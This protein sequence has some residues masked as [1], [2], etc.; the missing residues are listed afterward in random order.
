MTYSQTIMG[1]V[2]ANVKGYEL[3]NSN[4]WGTVRATLPEFEEIFGQCHDQGD[5]YNVS[6]E[7]F[8]ETPRGRATVRD[9]HLN[10]PDELSITSGNRGAALWL[11]VYLR[12]LKFKAFRGSIL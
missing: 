9:F 10:E 11:I 7:W 2:R 8:F 3:A 4:R 5:M 12:R 6:K 1:S